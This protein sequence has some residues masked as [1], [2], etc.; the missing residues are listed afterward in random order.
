M[1]DVM[2]NV[3]VGDDVLG[4]DFMVWV[5][6]EKS[7]DF[8]GMEVVFFCVSGMMINQIVINVYMRFGDEFICY[9]MVYIYVYEGGGIMVNLGVLVKFVGYDDGMFDVQQI[10]FVINFVD[11]YLL[12]I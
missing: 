7:V 4:E 6:E 2:M 1:F 10:V 11:I 3:F 12:C 9:Y 5:F 8:F